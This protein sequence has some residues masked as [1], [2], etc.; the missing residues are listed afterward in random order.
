M[1]SGPFS[2]HFYASELTQMPFQLINRALV[3]KKLHEEL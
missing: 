3:P 2:G 1:T